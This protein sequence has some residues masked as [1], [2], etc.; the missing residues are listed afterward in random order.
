VKPARNGTTTDQISFPLLAGLVL[1]LL[2]EIYLKISEIEKLFC[3]RQNCALS[4]LR[5]GQVSLYVHNFTILSKS[6]PTVDLIENTQKFCT[7][8]LAICTVEMLLKLCEFSL[9]SVYLT[10]VNKVKFLIWQLHLMPLKLQ[11]LCTSIVSDRN[12]TASGANSK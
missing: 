2:L 7:E 6:V 9:R 10:W 12:T 3:K 5:L 4:R 1:T 8:L 11:L